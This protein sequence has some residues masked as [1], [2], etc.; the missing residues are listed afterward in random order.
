MATTGKQAPRSPV[1]HCDE[2][3]RLIDEV[4][5]IEAAARGEPDKGAARP[6]R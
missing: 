6:H 2:V 4:L 1:S 3:I 5:G